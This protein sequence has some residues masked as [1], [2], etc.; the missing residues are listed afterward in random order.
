[1][2][3]RYHN[4]MLFIHVLFDKHQWHQIQIPSSPQG[5]DAL[6]LRETERPCRLPCGLPVVC[7]THHRS[8]PQCES[9]KLTKTQN[10]TCLS[11]GV[12]QTQRQRQRSL[13][14]PTSRTKQQPN[15]DTH[16]ITIK[17]C[18]DV[19]PKPLMISPCP[20]A[21]PGTDWRWDHSSAVPG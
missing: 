8:A 12:S 13:C 14:K 1:M 3:R 4:R 9:S 6:P 18:C 7:L 17:Y 5:H 15:Q 11:D 21:S 2:I 19:A 10:A 16:R 20:L